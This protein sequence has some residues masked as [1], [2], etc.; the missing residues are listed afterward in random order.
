M[1][2]IAPRPDQL[3]EA[4][5]GVP[6]GVPV[7]M[8][9]LLRFRELAA[10]PDGRPAISG[11]AA[12][13]KYSAEASTQVAQVGGSLV[14]IGEARGSV[15]GP[16]DEQWDQIFL[17]RYPSIEM[18]IRMIRSTAYQDIVVHRTAALKDS[19]LIVTVEKGN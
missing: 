19:R 10:Y 13:A 9:N 11:R 14:W 16:P 2:S 1:A 8:L 3:Q 5:S 7:V 15:I 18:F 12:Y 6:K 17:I 4:I